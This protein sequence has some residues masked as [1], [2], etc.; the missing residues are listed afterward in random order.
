MVIWGERAFADG[1]LYADLTLGTTGG[2]A[3]IERSDPGRVVRVV[4]VLK[5]EPEGAD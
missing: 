2:A 4:E 5:W 3:E 1:E